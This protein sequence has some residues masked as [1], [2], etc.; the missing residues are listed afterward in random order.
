MTRLMDKNLLVILLFSGFLATSCAS[1]YKVA[2]PVTGN[3]YY[4]EEVKRQ[5][6]AAVFKDARSGAQVTIQN[7]EISEVSKDEFEAGRTAPKAQPK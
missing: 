1:Y 7:S 3:I 2:D 5:G 6:S 4:T